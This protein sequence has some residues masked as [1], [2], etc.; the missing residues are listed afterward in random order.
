[1]G[2]R[3]DEKFLR[4]SGHAW[5]FLSRFTI[6]FL[7]VPCTGSSEAHFFLSRSLRAG[8]IPNYPGHGWVG[9]VFLSFPSFDPVHTDRFSDCGGGPDST[10]GPSCSAADL[11][12]DGDSD[13]RDIARFQ[14]E[15][16]NPNMI[17]VERF[18]GNMTPDFT[19]TTNWIDFPAGKQDSDLDRNF[20]RIGDFLNDYLH[21]VSAPKMLDY[22]FGSFV[23]RFSGYL[24]VHLEDEV[25]ENV[26]GLPVWIDVGVL[27]YDAYSAY[28][29]INIFREINVARP[30]GQFFTNFGPSTEVLGLFPIRIVYY[31]ID[32][33]DNRTGNGRAGVE[34]YSWHGGGLPW[35]GGFN[36]VH[37]LRGPA[38]LIPPWV[39]YQ[40]EDIQPIVKGDFEADADIDLKDFR[41]FTICAN[42]T[43]T[44]TPYWC[45]PFDINNN[46]RVLMSEY[47][48]FRSR[49]LGPGVPAP[50]PSVP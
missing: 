10:I 7:A 38:T 22:P 34:A 32:D 18:L 1:M 9:E 33:P 8:A 25:R 12:R 20:Q 36:M 31:N 46:G 5:L 49:M 29:G 26:L 17:W 35:P 40:A 42:P 23:I 45:E 30:Q 6:G 37:P 14:I 2:G 44:F 16:G 21:N 19:F 43:F 48:S 11:D 15:Y 4:S 13:L 50:P 24:G 27:G 39:I 28:V 41:W 47:E 3:S